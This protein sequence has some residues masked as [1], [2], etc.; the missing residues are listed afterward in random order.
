M[1][2]YRLF[3]LSYKKYNHLILPIGLIF[4][5]LIFDLIIRLNKIILF[6]FSESIFFIISILMLYSLLQ[7]LSDLVSK[8][9]TSSLF[10]FYAVK[11]LLIILFISMFSVIILLYGFFLYFGTLPNSGIIENILLEPAFSWELIK[12][13]INIYVILGACAIVIFSSYI[14]SLHEKTINKNVKW[15]FIL[16][17]LGLFL[18][19]FG[20][21]LI[22][23]SK[24]EGCQVPLS[25]VIV[26]TTTFFLKEKKENSSGYKY[27]TLRVPL[28]KT[29]VTYNVILIINESVRRDIMQ[30]YGNNVLN[31]P[32]LFHF[33]NKYKGNFFQFSR[34]RTNSTMT[35]LSVPSILKGVSPNV[36][37]MTWYLAP[38]LWDYA[39]SVGLN[40]FFISAHCFKWSRWENTLLNSP[41]LD[42]IYTECQYTEAHNEIHHKK[43]G[44]FDDRIFISKMIKHIRGLNKNNLNFCGVLHLNGTHYPYWHL[45]ENRI[46]KESSAI[47]NYHNSIYQQDLA[48]KELYKFLEDEGLLANTFIAYTSD[49]GEAF[50]EH[51][52]HGHL[53]NFYEEDIGIPLWFYIPDQILSELDNFQKENINTNQS[54]N[55]CNLDILPTLI[56]LLKIT[57]DFQFVK[58]L[59]GC[60]FASPIRNDR[61]VYIT[62]YNTLNFKTMNQS[63]AM[64]CDSMKWIYHYQNEKIIT[65][66]YN[67]V[68][69]S[70]EKKNLILDNVE[71]SAKNI[72]YRLLRLKK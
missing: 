12:A 55:V 48:L 54:N 33:K 37:E 67:V 58:K 17:Q 50:G 34:A 36:D 42:F 44:L 56:D 47:A 8:I 24:Y 49:H 68:N 13:N 21:L 46:I 45:F 57:K 41:S 2:I 31:S 23:S 16:S 69:D 7:F 60:S 4:C 14:V 38:F 40:T 6:N 26:N 64:I 61:K 5:I 25:Q 43:L 66:C 53:M 65:K 20:T 9:Q 27:E 15:K 19:T 18:I 62:N 71:A 63:Y 52:Y 1:S 70:N 35:L 10:I 30:I 28:N 72:D 32:N 22:A 29:Q 39:K 11:I 51:G 59:G 3:P